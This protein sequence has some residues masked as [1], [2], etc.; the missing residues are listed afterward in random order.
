MRLLTVVFAAGLCCGCFAF[1]ELDSGMEAMEKSGP[2]SDSMKKR[3]E[4]AR[5]AEPDDDGPGILEH[6]R[7]W[8]ENQKRQLRE[9][10]SGTP[11][12]TPA[13]PKNAIVRCEVDGTTQFT[14]KYDCEHRG[15]RA[16]EFEPPPS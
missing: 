16:V 15:G 5:P 13:D 10:S 12:R 2:I 8:W 14:H 3:A 7:R 6:A 11:A 1:D 9:Q 4:P